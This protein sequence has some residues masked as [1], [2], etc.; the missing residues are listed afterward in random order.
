MLLWL[1]L[2]LVPPPPPSPEIKVLLET[3]REGK[4]EACGRSFQIGGWTAPS[5]V[6]FTLSGGAV[7]LEDPCGKR[8]P[9][10]GSVLLVPDGGGFTFKGKTYRGKARLTAGTK[11]AL[12]INQVEVEDYLLGVVPAEMGPREYPSLE[13]LKAQAV[14]ARSYAMAK[15]KKPDNANYHLCDTPACQVYEGK[16]IEKPLTDRAVKETCGLV[17]KDPAGSVVEAFFTATCGGHTTLGTN[18]FPGGPVSALFPSQ[19]CHPVPE[20]T[21]NAR[22]KSPLGPAAAA[23]AL[24]WDGDFAAGL[25]RAFGLAVDP[26]DPCAGLV[27]FFTGGP[28]TCS[29]LFAL[30]VFKEAWVGRMAGEGDAAMLWEVAAVL[31]G[32][33]GRLTKKTGVFSLLEGS[34]ITLLEEDPQPLCLAPGARLYLRRGGQTASVTALSLTP[35]DRLEWW[36][37]AGNALALV[38]EERP[39]GGIADGRAKLA[40]W[41][42]F[43]PWEEI[44]E[45]TGVPGAKG[46]EVVRSSPEGRVLSLKITGA[47][48][49]KTLERLDVRFKLGLPELLFKVLPVRDGAFFLGSGWGHG[50]GMCQEGAFGMGASG[51]DFKTILNYYYP[52]FA[53]VPYQ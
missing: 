30:P 2:L 23:A 26:A 47:K 21:L 31:L 18:L 46:L 44:A 8:A 53:V 16:D 36:G 17:L 43:L 48:G 27:A 10:S 20:Y 9:Y 24:A 38:K 33:A 51:L 19:P 29:A 37:D 40:Q 32:E 25:K 50:V 34:T 14:A 52:Q 6:H 11:H 22:E 41:L 49:S 42:R 7:M 45:K 3:V 13:A 4:L 1:I 39:V 12:V 15:L 35:G 28:G 5:P